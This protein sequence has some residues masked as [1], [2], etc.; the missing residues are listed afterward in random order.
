M[1]EID[2][3]VE[4]FAR[5][6]ADPEALAKMVGEWVAQRWPERVKAA[7]WV[8][9]SGD[10]D[11]GFQVVI[12][13]KKLARWSFYGSALLGRKTWGGALFVDVGEYELPG[14]RKVAASVGLGAVTPYDGD[15]WKMVAAVSLRF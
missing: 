11:K 8:T 2:Q 14:E 13:Q 7:Y 12:A 10:Y 3:Q 1:N 9:V 5:V 4:K 15:G 6:A